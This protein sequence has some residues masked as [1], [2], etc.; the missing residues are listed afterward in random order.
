[1]APCGNLHRVIASNMG[2][3]VRRIE[4]SRMPTR[5]AAIVTSC[6]AAPASMTARS[7]EPGATVSGWCAS[8]RD[9]VAKYNGCCRSEEH[10][11]EL[12]SLMRIS[13]GVFC[14]KKK[15]QTNTYD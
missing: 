7:L 3:R 1:M 13:Y 10:T 12:Q 8:K 4:P 2:W 6:T 11:F 9:S 14:L 5:S 15:K